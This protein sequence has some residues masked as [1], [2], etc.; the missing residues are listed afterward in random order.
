[1]NLKEVR[2]PKSKIEITDGIVGEQ[3][4][5]GMIMVNGVEFEQKRMLIIRINKGLYERLLQKADDNH[6]I[7][8]NLIESYLEDA[9]TRGAIVKRPEK[10]TPVLNVGIKASVS[11]ERLLSHVKEKEKNERRS[12][13]NRL[14]NEEE[15][16]PQIE[17]P[18]EK[19]DVPNTEGL[20]D[21]DFD[22]LFG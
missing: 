14:K 22:S 10:P 6:V 8:A 2:F 7:L 16:E 13:I 5:D 21:L 18:D 1:M 12:L 4:G 17:A 15:P 9:L 11:P 20:D 3:K 19:V